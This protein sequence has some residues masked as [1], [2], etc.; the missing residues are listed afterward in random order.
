M[1]VRRWALELQGCTNHNKAD[2]ALASFQQPLE[3]IGAAVT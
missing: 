3:L 2:C 1:R